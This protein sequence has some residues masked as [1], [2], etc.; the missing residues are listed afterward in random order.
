MYLQQT[1]A[2]Q[3]ITMMIG[4][5]KY[6]Q[7]KELVKPIQFSIT[8]QRK[9]CW[10]IWPFDAEKFDHH[11]KNLF[12]L[13]NKYDANCWINCHLQGWPALQYLEDKLGMARILG[14]LPGWWLWHCRAEA[15]AH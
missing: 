13:L 2:L 10:R 14:E 4:T 7:K 11:E 5:K 12:F 6:R 1:S 8:E 9:N 15:Y 3:N